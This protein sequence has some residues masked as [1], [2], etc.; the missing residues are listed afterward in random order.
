MAVQVNL[1]QYNSMN[2]RMITNNL[3]YTYTVY[4]N[5]YCMQLCRFVENIYFL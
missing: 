1:L 5:L 2:V 4:V 3:Y